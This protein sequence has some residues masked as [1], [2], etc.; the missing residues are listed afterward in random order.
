MEPKLPTPSRGPELPSVVAPAAGET[1]EAFPGSEVHSGSTIEQRER[2]AEAAPA[3]EA[4][5]ISLPVLPIPVV[6]PVADDD[7]AATVTPQASSA[8]P[9][10]A[11]DDELIER[12]WVD[13]A[14]KVITE[15]R[16]DPYAREQRVSQ[17]QA[18]YLWKRY[19]RQLKS[20]Q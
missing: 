20:P 18:D 9:A 6:T 4:S 7:D 5:A 13:R 16:D 12:E 2:G 8:S 15:T 3:A 11:N 19:G 17:L 14:K 1:R 10:V